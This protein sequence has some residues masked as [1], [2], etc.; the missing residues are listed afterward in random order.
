MK[1]LVLVIILGAA[2]AAFA[3]SANPHVNK[4]M[5][6]GGCR[7]CHQGHGESGSPML[8]M[9][10]RNLCLQCH[11]SPGQLQS[12]VARG[13]VSGSSRPM[14]MDGILNLVS[15]HPISDEA[16]SR[17]QQGSVTC[18]SC[19]SAHR[20]NAQKP[21][22]DEPTGQRRLS[23]RD[24]TQF[25][26]T[27][28]Q[29][30]H[31]SGGA[32]TQDLLDISRLTAPDNRSFHPVEAP[33]IEG[34]PSV[35]PALSGREINCTDCHGNASREGPKGPHGSPVPFLLR[36][37]YTTADGSSE[38]PTV[39]ALCY[40]CHRREMVLKQ[41]LFPEHSEHIVEQQASCA[42]CHNP[43]GSVNNRALIR[44]GEETTVAGVSASISTGRLEF[45]SDG[46]SSGACYL[47]CHGVD[48]GP[49]AYGAM[50]SL[51]E[52]LGS[53][54]PHDNRIRMPQDMRANHK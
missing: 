16:F 44:F 30:C 39:Y 3:S 19:H 35:L 15:V 41:E 31:G 37:N 42:T 46:P 10:Q 28:C 7:S 51:L 29:E 20:G 11:G 25:E 38:S 9:G 54:V 2:V 14:Q 43:H 52:M 18:T 33:A 40:R 49:Q 13:L 53:R 36:A 4:S 12:M 32:S 6:P 48:H 50:K 21:S 17:R 8:S 34:S 26:F 23:P 5:N 24:A 47:T 27:L 1:H 45:V 22:Q